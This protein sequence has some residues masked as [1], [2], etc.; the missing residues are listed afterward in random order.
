MATC[1]HYK[2]AEQEESQQRGCVQGDS[3]LLLIADDTMPDEAHF[4]SESSVS[5]AG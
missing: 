5:Y 2:V 3:R 4:H 1:E